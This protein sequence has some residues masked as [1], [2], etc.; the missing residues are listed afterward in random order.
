MIFFPGIN[1][2][3]VEPNCTTND[4]TR[5]QK[6]IRLPF[7]PF[8][9]ELLK[10]LV[11]EFGDKDW[12]LIASHMEGRTVRQC[13]ERWQNNLSSTVIKS[14]WTKEEDKTLKIK[15]SEFGPKWKL[16]EE[17]FPGRTSYNIRNRWNGLI[18]IKKKSLNNQKINNVSVPTKQNC[19]QM[20]NEQIISNIKLNEAQNNFNAERSLST[21][22]YI[23]PMI[24]NLEN[25]NSNAVEET[26]K[27][28]KEEINNN[29][30]YTIRFDREPSDEDF[31]ADAIGAPFFSCEDFSFVDKCF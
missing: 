7:K 23:V 5:I 19:R 31:F 16:L 1:P 17:F 18:R 27:T 29:N 28:K 25:N 6:K 12:S 11:E 3:S 13:R 22:K 15:Y 14:K 24:S 10:K 2:S 26:K 30:I 8:E 4:K 20:H 21:Q 9:D